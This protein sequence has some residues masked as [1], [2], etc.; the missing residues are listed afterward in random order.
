MSYDA[1][2]EVDGA[3]FAARIAVADGPAF[4]LALG[5]TRLE[6]TG[7]TCDSFSETAALVR[8]FRRHATEDGLS[9]SFDQEKTLPFG[10]EYQLRRQIELSNASARFLVDVRA[11]APGRLRSFELDRTVMTG[12]F[13]RFGILTA[14]ADSFDW[15]TPAEEETV[16]YDA[17]R[18]FL[19]LSVEDEAGNRIDFGCGADLW[20]HA[21]GGSERSFR[22]AGSRSA[23]VIERRPL[24]YPAEEEAP[25]RPWRFEY[26]LAWQPGGAPTPPTPERA[27]AL[28][29]LDIPAAGRREDGQGFC[30]AAPAVRRRLREL[31]RGSADSFLLRGV[32]PGVCGDPAHVERPGGTAR[33]HWDLPE[34]FAFRLWAG[35]Q[36]AARRN[37][38][39]F[40]LAPPEK[41][42]DTAAAGALAA[43]LAGLR[44]KDR[45]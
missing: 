14:E 40:E 11:E 24:G 43:P 10:C 34:L 7:M 21:G 17:D 20:R 33:P 1:I 5:D 3:A 32:A 35:R 12:R 44:L 8:K 23:L 15:R 39:V 18:P 6:I 28:D 2:A 37:F 9:L 41:W 36:L 4:A 27:V 29:E 38:A 25:K 30:L 45:P 42:R 13:R 19:A 16:L 22:I 26:F 31:V